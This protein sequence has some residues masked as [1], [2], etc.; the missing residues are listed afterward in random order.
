MVGIAGQFFGM[1]PPEWWRIVQFGKPLWLVGLLA[2]VPVI[3]FWATSRV[4]AAPGRRWVS[5]V[6]RII[7]VVALV[8]GLAETRL[9]WPNKGVCVAFLIDQSQSVPEEVRQLMRGR[10]EDEISNMTKDDQFMI[11]EFGGDAVLEA[12]P[13][14]RGKL[15]LAVAVQDSGRTDI[16]R[17]IRLA[18]ASFPPDKQKRIV[19]LS[20]GNQ[21]VGDALREARIAAA[22]QNVDIA[23]LTLSAQVGHEVMVEQL[24]IPNRVQKGTNFTV[25]TMISSDIAQGGKLTLIRD[26]RVLQANSVQLKPGMNIF[27]V[28]DNL[29]DGGF[30]HYEVQIAPDKYDTF[31]ANNYSYGFTRVD[32]PGRVL[33]IHGDANQRDYLYDALLEDG[34]L[35]D[36]GSIDQF[37]S[38]VPGLMAYD[39]VVLDNVSADQFHSD[40]RMKMLQDWVEDTGG[41]LVLIGGDNSFGPGGY[42]GT[43]LEAISPVEMDIKN[44]KHQATVAVVIVLDKSGS[45]GEPIGSGKTKMDL[46]NNG[47]VE[48]LKLLSPTDFAQIGAVDTEVHWQYGDHLI[49]LTDSNVRH[50]TE[51]T[52]SNVAGGGG[53]YC[54]TALYHAYKTVTDP[55]IHAMSRHVILFAD[56]ADS[57]QQE[58]CYALADQYSHMSPPVTLSVIG[59]GETTDSDV[60][61]QRELARRG[62][63]RSEI[64]DDP[65]KLP[66][67]FMKDV[68]TVSR[69]AY[70]EKPEG[71][72]PRMFDS[73]LLEGF[74]ET[75]FPKSYGYVGTTLKV[76]P[77][78][79]EALQGLEADDPFM[80][81]WQTGL[82][83]VVAFMSDSTSKWS[84]DW[85]QWPGYAKF[86]G[87]AVRWASRSAHNSQITT[88]SRIEGNNI[89]LD[90][91]AV[92]A[93]GK[94]DNSQN[95]SSSTLTSDPDA[96]PI[97]APIVQI[98][99]GH[100]SGVI[101]INRP[102]GNIT[103][104]RDGA[105]KPV[106]S[107]GTVLSY[108]P[109]FRD[110][111]PNTGLLKAMADATGGKML[112][113]LAGVFTNKDDT[114]RTQWPLWN[115][116]MVIVAVG[117]LV[118]IAW[119]RLNFADYFRR[120]PMPSP[121]M[122]T[123]TGALGAL[124][125]IHKGRG[126][127]DQQRQTLRQRIAA[128]DQGAG[129][130]QSAGG[131]VVLDMASKQTDAGPTE[132]YATRLAAAKRRAAKA[133]KEHDER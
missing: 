98:G 114:V 119:R 48:A 29:A 82:G 32:A 90:I 19:L 106:D 100:Y 46:A 6:L 107:I 118:D 53:I 20:D 27:D 31:T 113:D 70:V 122:G 116:L 94:P 123:A 89:R 74:K 75:G 4:P 78:A 81:H 1:V 111:T 72:T 9:S 68:F 129:S 54:K 102:G 84:K 2:L 126:E 37:P 71:F 86:W 26:G 43:P 36:R 50:L 52:L 64:T 41:G 112:S 7:L 44:K 11:I 83:K 40:V 65:L 97:P 12:L 76:K 45:M 51:Q 133:I 28:T 8:L 14:F 87:Q 93:S 60:P 121:G 77:R 85:V 109:E 22:G 49:P 66:R 96:P 56:T 69:N 80:A 99:P 35:A 130:Q 117:L 67:L 13:S 127:V 21:N 38:T 103:T 23:P 25:R 62:H 63:G 58:D 108:P 30:H 120:M 3:Y 47:A 61:F 131:P 73:P 16:S 101:P 92:D 5:L 17:A 33:V 95:F 79:T 125:N 39:C 55:S 18:E 104:I 110:L 34:V 128:A 57:E 115:V 10:I 132:G 105:G 59:L 91:N 24:L 88:T 42:K 15:P 124:R